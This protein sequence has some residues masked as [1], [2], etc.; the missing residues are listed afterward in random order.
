MLCSN[1]SSI[2]SPGTRAS[3]AAARRASSSGPL[4]RATA[5]ATR[6][7]AA[8]WASRREAF[9]SL[10]LLVPHPASPILSLLQ[11]S[12][13]PQLPHRLAAGVH[14][15]S[16][17]ER[18]RTGPEAQLL[19]RSRHGE[20]R[21][22]RVPVGHLQGDSEPRLDEQ[23]TVHALGAH[24]HDHPAGVRAHHLR[25]GATLTGDE[26][27]V[28]KHGLDDAGAGSGE[29]GAAPCSRLPAP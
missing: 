26:I 8:V 11:S 12:I 22:D 19:E 28:A 9:L 23:R 16:S 29:R 21:R 27:G 10:I 17:G 13:Y 6:T 18:G 4:P 24:F 2:H 5:A 25:T 15:G 20:R 1:S 7:R 14:G 3:R